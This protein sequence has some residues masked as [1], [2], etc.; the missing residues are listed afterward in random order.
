MVTRVGFA[1]L[2]PINVKN[3]E[4]PGKVVNNGFVGKTRNSTI[5]PLRYSTIPG[6]EIE[7]QLNC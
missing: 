4:S 5:Q 1:S 3:N 7:N 6:F 2:A